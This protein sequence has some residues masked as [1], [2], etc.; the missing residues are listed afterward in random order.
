ME[1]N[2]MK[3][4]KNIHGKLEKYRPLK[5]KIPWKEMCFL[6]VLECCYALKVDGQI[7]LHSLHILKPKTTN[8]S[9]TLLGYWVR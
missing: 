3:R 8:K 6:M 5:K 4:E 1:G 2:Q 9:K 7:Q